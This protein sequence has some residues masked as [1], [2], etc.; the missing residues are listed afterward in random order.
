MSEAQRKLVGTLL[1]RALQLHHERG[2]IGLHGDCVGAD[3]DFDDLCAERGIERHTMPCTAGEEL[4]AHC[5]ERGAIQVADPIKP[6]DRN[7]V[8]VAQAEWMLACPPTQEELKRGG[9]WFTVREARKRDD[10][11]L[12]VIL[13][14]GKIVE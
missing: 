14:Y 6:L 4:R 7:R 12:Y 8:I 2:I 11:P 1:D 10:L 13:P 9:T 3:K 5:E